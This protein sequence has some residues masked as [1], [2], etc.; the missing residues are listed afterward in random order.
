MKSSDPALPTP[1]GRWAPETLSLHARP[2]SGIKNTTFSVAE[3]YI[4]GMKSSP[5]LIAGLCAVVVTS[6]MIA[7][8]QYVFTATPSA[9][10]A[11]IDAL[12]PM[13]R[14]ALLR[15]LM[16]LGPFAGVLSV[17]ITGLVAIS[18]KGKVE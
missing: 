17:F 11:A 8:C 13:H 9:L 14:E 1:P 12:S 16:Y 18:R 7:L 2:D 4:G 10:K 3:D 15:T 5:K 6:L